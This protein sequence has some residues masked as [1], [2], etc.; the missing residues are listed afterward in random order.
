MKD[1]KELPWEDAG[2]AS[3]RG[4][5]VCKSAE[6]GTNPGMNEKFRESQGGWAGGTRE[7]VVRTRLEQGLIRQRLAA[8][9]TRSGVNSESTG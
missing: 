3:G 1:D 2:G 4:N 6:M 7:P 8:R 5:S 9:G